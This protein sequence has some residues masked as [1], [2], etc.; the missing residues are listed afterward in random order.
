MKNKRKAMLT[1][2]NEVNANINPEQAEIQTVRY[3]DGNLEGHEK[4][5]LEDIIRIHKTARKGLFPYSFGVTWPLGEIIFNK[6][7]EAA[8]DP[9]VPFETIEETVLL[10]LNTQMDI[11]NNALCSFRS[12][13]GSTV[14]K[15]CDFF[16]AFVKHGEKDARYYD[17]IYTM[18]THRLRENGSFSLGFQMNYGK[19][20]NTE[21][22]AKLPKAMQDRLQDETFYHD[23]RDSD[24]RTCYHLLT[25]ASIGM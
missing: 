16:K 6:L 9:K 20:F 12:R 23:E 1:T 4:W 13:N 22:L 21:V 24:R 8:N 17:L 10:V 5:T 18:L 25:G 14:Q 3:W 7:L 15:V 19:G 11:R 2:D